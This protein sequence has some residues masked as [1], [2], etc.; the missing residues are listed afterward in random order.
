MPLRSIA[1]A[2]LEV[3]E[4]RM[5]PAVLIRSIARAPLKLMSSGCARRRLRRRR[6]QLEHINAATRSSLGRGTV[7]G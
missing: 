2:P 7:G 6:T 1:R 4:F 5:R 3:D